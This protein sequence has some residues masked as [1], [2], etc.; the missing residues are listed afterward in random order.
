MLLLTVCK[1]ISSNGLTDRH[2]RVLW[3]FDTKSWQLH[4][5]A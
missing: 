2:T 5:H 4:L 3:G 1:Q